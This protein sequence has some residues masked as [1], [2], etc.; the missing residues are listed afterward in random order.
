MRDDRIIGAGANL[1]L[2]PDQRGLLLGDLAGQYRGLKSRLSGG[3]GYC[4]D[5]IRRVK[6]GLALLREDPGDLIGAGAQVA[7]LIATFGDRVL[8]CDRGG[9]GA[10]ERDRYRRASDAGR[11]GQQIHV[12]LRNL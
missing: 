7:H 9:R 12:D 11:F 6:S 8:Q 2:R 5:P 10:G 4:V 1:S 3:G